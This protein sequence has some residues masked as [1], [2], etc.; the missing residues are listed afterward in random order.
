MTV[1]IYDT[2][3]QLAKE[4]PQTQQFINLQLVYANLKKDVM[5]YNLFKQFTDLQEK[6]QKKQLNGE[7]ITEDEMKQIQNL[8]AKMNQMDAIK[9]LMASEEALN[10]LLVEMNQIIT[11]PISAL[12]EKE[13]K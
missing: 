10:Q 4:L 5:A 8:A 11:E 1:N 9:Q 2:A 6:L 13:D 12:Y 7:K 3:N